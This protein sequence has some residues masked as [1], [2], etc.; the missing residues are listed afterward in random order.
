MY[1]LDDYN[2][3]KIIFDLEVTLQLDGRD[4]QEKDVGTIYENVL[5]RISKQYGL[6]LKD[7]PVT[8][9][10]WYAG[11]RR[12]DAVLFMDNLTHQHGRLC[13]YL[14]IVR[15][16][17]KID[18]KASNIN[19]AGFTPN[20]MDNLWIACMSRMLIPNTKEAMMSLEKRFSTLGM[21]LEKR[22]LL[23]LMITHRLGLYEIVAAIAEIFYLGGRV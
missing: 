13:G 23:I 7:A 17:Q 8:D 18:I 14:Q 3:A 22:L 20:S 5:R 21:C 4:Y 6:N 11:E 9:A 2:I 1:I 15:Y 12:T 10:S 19:F 16:I